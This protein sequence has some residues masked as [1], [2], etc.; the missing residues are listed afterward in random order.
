MAPPPS[1]AH[2]RAHTHTTR[3]HTQDHCLYDLLIRFKSG[4]LSNCA[5]P[6]IVSNHPDLQAVADMFG[7]PFRCL[8]IADKGGWVGG[9]VLWRAVLLP[10]GR[11]QGWVGGCVC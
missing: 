6:V 10:A 9:W 7:V 1:R 4:E 11:G 5:I 2:A 3:T 8:P